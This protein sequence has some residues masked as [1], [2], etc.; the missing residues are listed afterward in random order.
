MTGIYRF[1]SSTGGRTVEVMTSTMFAPS[2]L[3]VLGEQIAD[4]GFDRYAASLQR[5]ATAARVAG[6]RVDLADLLVDDTAPDAVRGRALSAVS[7][8][9]EAHRATVTPFAQAAWRVAAMPIPQTDPP[10]VAA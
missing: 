2:E 3:A 7:A 4:H 9:L 10:P 8:A 5:V 1:C 6:V